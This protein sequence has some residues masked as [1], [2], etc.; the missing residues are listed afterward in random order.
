[1]NFQTDSGFV[2]H[3]RTL[4]S[5]TA[6]IPGDERSA[7]AEPAQ[8]KRKAEIQSPSLGPPSETPD[9]RPKIV[10]GRRQTWANLY[11]TVDRATVQMAADVVLGP[12]PLHRLSVSSS[13]Q[14]STTSSESP[15][16]TPGTPGAFNF[17]FRYPSSERS[18]EVIPKIEELDENDQHP[19]DV[20]PIV[21]PDSLPSPAQ[22]VVKRPRGRPRKHPIPSPTAVSKP[23]K[24]RSKTG[25]ITCRKRKKKCDERRPTCKFKFFLIYVCVKADERRSALRKEQRPLRGLSPKGVLEAWQ[26]Q[27][28][29]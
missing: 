14:P 23:S 29:R 9:A 5:N 1:M 10:H 27:R 25:C 6:N 11:R 3:I 8:G 20:S 17:S 24:G 18:H 16:H 21:P 28:R 12:A 15:Q 2:E 13:S 4:T 26:K 7:S 22:A 19:G